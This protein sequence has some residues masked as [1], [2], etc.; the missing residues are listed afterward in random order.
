MSRK[1]RSLRRK[2]FKIDA[3]ELLRCGERNLDSGFWR[4]IPKPKAAVRMSF[5]VFKKRFYLFFR[6]ACNVL[7]SLYFESWKCL[8]QMFVCVCHSSLFVPLEILV[9]AMNVRDAPPNQHTSGT[10]E[11]RRSWKPRPVVKQWRKKLLAVEVVPWLIQSGWKD[12]MFQFGKLKKSQDLACF[13]EIMIICVF[14]PFGSKYP[15]PFIDDLVD[16]YDKKIPAWI[17]S[18]KSQPL[19]SL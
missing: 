5:W 1:T 10:V 6:L 15:V 9:I 11:A 13:S 17:S 7:E 14:N 19:C 18:T 2:I 12:R 4:Q 8:K 16:F 3:P